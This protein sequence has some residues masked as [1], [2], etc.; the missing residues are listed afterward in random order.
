MVI[1]AI[2]FDSFH[3]KNVEKALWPI[4]VV[5]AIQVSVAVSENGHPAVVLQPSALGDHSQKGPGRS[6]RNA[7][8]GPGF[9]PSGL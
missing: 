4:T 6:S 7:Q 1:T 2:F 3:A 8:G 5:T 9:N